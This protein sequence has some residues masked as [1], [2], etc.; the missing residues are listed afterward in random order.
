MF[1]STRVLQWKNCRVGGGGGRKV[2]R[3]EWGRRV[4]GAERILWYFTNFKYDKIQVGVVI[5]DDSKLFGH[6]AI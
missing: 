5:E 3:E 4:E 2:Q 1:R 6:F